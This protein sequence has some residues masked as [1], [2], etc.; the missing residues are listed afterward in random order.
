[1][2]AR[3]AL[4]VLCIFG[5]ASARELLDDANAT[6]AFISGDEILPVMPLMSMLTGAAE[7]RRRARRS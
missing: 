4:A 5:G 1:M 3:V 6:T 2:L 7:A